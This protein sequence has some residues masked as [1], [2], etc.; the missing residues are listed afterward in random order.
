MPEKVI[1]H[2]INVTLSLSAGDGSEELTDDFY[3]ALLIE[4]E[5]IRLCTLRELL[6]EEVE[7][8]E[9]LDTNL[10]LPAGIAR[11]RGVAKYAD[12]AALQIRKLA[13]AWGG[14]EPPSHP[15]DFA[16]PRDQAIWNAQLR[17]GRQALSKHGIKITEKAL[18]DAYHAMNMSGDKA[19]KEIYYNS[20]QVE[21][22]NEDE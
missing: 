12:E 14:D 6:M 21:D 7:L 1:S 22:D 2:K 19:I 18:A 17:A 8:S 20:P 4:N 11:F 13:A 5:E 16:G 10:Q 3:V 15:L 9:Q